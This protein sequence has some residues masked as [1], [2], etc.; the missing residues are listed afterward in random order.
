MNAGTNSRPMITRVPII[1]LS[2]GVLCI[3]EQRLPSCRASIS[4]LIHLCHNSVIREGTHR[5]IE[6]GGEIRRKE[7]EKKRKRERKSTLNF[8]SCF[9]KSIYIARFI[10]F[11]NFQSVLG[12][13]VKI[14]PRVIF[15]NSSQRRFIVYTYKNRKIRIFSPS[16][17]HSKTLNRKRIR[18]KDRS[19]I[20]W[21]ISRALASS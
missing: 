19:P 4:S 1:N 12:Y 21:P 2:L 11:I 9:Y 16:L 13:G 18:D 5:A 15:C 3:V 8:E 10:I 17:T 7:R 20:R 14:S 6:V